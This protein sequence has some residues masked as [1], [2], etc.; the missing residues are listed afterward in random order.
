MSG[1]KKDSPDA[2]AAPD[3]YRTAAAQAQANREALLTS[4][5]INRFQELTPFGSVQWLGPGGVPAGELT[6]PT[7]QPYQP[8][9]TSPLGGKF[10][11]RIAQRQA[12]LPAPTEDPRAGQ[13]TRVV[14]LDPAEQA[15]LEQQRQLA[16]ALGGTAL[17]R[18]EQLTAE[19]FGLEG[20]SPLPGVGDFG[21]ERQRV[22]EALYGRMTSRLDPRFE[23]EQR[24]LETRLANQGIPVGS[25]AWQQAMENFGMR[26]EDAYQAALADAIAAGGQEQSRLFGLGMM[27][28]QQGISE[29]LMERQQP[30][31]ELAQILGGIPPIQ[32]G[33]FAQPAQYQAA[34]ADVQGAIG[35]G[36]Q[37]ALNQYNQQMA[38]QQAM[39][40]GLFG[41]GGT[42]GAA[43]LLG[44]YMCWVAEELYGPLA[45][46]TVIVRAYVQ[47]HIDSHSLLGGFARAYRKH[48]RTWA[49]WVRAHPLAR[50]LARPIW[51]HLYRLAV[52]ELENGKRSIHTT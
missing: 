3:P 32:Q 4:A 38:Q 1:G 52:K 10:A 46:K 7:A 16:A 51:D 22:E 13:W 43:Y 18:A 17:T 21:G 34:P 25:E 20:I 31:T 28:R 48:G 41:L 26:R 29:R 12:A 15:Q 35:M 9:P 50:L 5:E 14:S 37:G 47:S 40:S 39:M 30:M 2:P 19:P 44:P 11:D 49:K 23:Q 33:Q 36:Y 6:A 24:A 42:L 27:G 45:E 8:V